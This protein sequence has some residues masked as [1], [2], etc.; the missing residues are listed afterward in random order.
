MSTVVEVRD[1]NKI[2]FNQPTDVLKYEKEETVH[3]TSMP[4]D[5]KQD[6]FVIR[7]RFYASYE[8]IYDVRIFVM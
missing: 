6:L 4:W 2:D 5:S 7:K 8:I 3:P 1:P